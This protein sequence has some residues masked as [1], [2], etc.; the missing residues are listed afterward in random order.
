MK[1]IS[2]NQCLT[3]TTKRDRLTWQ[4]NLTQKVNSLKTELNKSIRY[5]KKK[6]YLPNDFIIIVFE[7]YG[8]TILKRPIIL[9]LNIKFHKWKN[10][11]HSHKHI[12][13]NDTTKYHRW[14]HNRRIHKSSQR[15]IANR[16]K[17]EIGLRLETI[18]LANSTQK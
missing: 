7:T 16:N 11:Q 17:S 10:R 5:I 4:Y 6:K 13:K 3:Q 9:H 18:T 12:Y 1:D 2:F 14:S 8:R 15:C